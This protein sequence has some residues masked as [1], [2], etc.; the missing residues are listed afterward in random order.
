MRRDVSSKRAAGQAT[1]EYI[2]IIGLIVIP[3]A[4]AYNRLAEVLRGL[5]RS[6]CMLLYGPGL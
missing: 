5:V 3:I 6:I 1:T 4:V 2:L